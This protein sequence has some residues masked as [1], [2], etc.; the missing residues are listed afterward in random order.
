MFGSELTDEHFVSVFQSLGFTPSV[1]HQFVSIFSKPGIVSSYG[2]S[3]HL[4]SVV[5]EMHA[6]SW[7][8]IQSSKKLSQ[9]TR[10]SEPGDPLGDI[11]FDSLAAEILSETERR[12]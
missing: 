4:N 11:I 2:A 8:C 12:A 10:G 3:K 5:S 9:T 1:S 7:F 6:L